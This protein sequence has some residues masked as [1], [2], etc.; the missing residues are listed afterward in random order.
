MA[1]QVKLVRREDSATTGYDV[2]SI[3]LLSNT[4]GFD[5]DYYD[6]WTQA[7][8][9][10]LTPGNLA[11]TLNLIATG[12]DKDDLAANLQGLDDK[13]KQTEWYWD[14]PTE[15]YGVWLRAQLTGESY[16]RQ[17]LIRRGEGQPGESLYGPYTDRGN[18]MRRYAL[19][20]E[21]LPWWE[22][23]DITYNSISGTSFGGGIAAACGTVHGDIPA[24]CAYTMLNPTDINIDEFW[25]GFRNN[26]RF[27]VI[28]NFEPQWECEDG[29]VLIA[30]TTAG[31][32][33]M[34][35]TFATD[36]TM[37][38]RFYVQISDVT[39]N[40]SDQRGQ[41]IVLMR[42][43]L[44][45][46]ATTTRVRLLDGY[47]TTA[48]NLRRQDRVV[49]DSTEW[50]LY[51]LGTVQIPPLAGL[52]TLDMFKS[53]RLLI[54]AE[55]TSGAGFLRCDSFIL[56]PIGE[57]AIY[58]SNIQNTT[59]DHR[60]EIIVSPDGNLSGWTLAESTATI[61]NSIS[62]RPQGPYGYTLPVG[63]G[64]AIFTGQSATAHSSFAGVTFAC[65]INMIERWRTLRGADT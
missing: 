54:Q 50:K 25:M 39:A 64:F 9:Q 16:A 11:E 48:S 1:V 34:T 35:T 57:G 8:P 52:T 41:F 12:D 51:P 3:S 24:R 20:L 44:S 47:S 65:G 62:P 10:G 36:E 4:N 28:A 56:I 23:T 33:Y 32:T 31:A 17:A 21:R 27:G 6:G 15:R 40:Y 60:T 14:D 18:V 58:V 26:T 61:T 55:R 49:I 53:Y 2:S 29:T 38:S 63:S 19:A 7:V 5:L 30:D 45:A 59:N 46:G 22:D 37:A 42:A 43:Q 13:L